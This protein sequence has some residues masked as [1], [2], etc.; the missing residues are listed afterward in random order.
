MS[1]KL[2]RPGG[3]LSGT[4]KARRDV[5]LFPSLAHSLR[6]HKLRSPYSGD[7]D[8]VFANRVGN[9]FLQGNV[10]SLLVYQGRDIVF[11]SRQLGHANPKITLEIYADLWNQAEQAEAMRQGME[12]DFA[13]MVGGNGP[14]TNDGRGG[15]RTG[16]AEAANLVPLGVLR[17]GGAPS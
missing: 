1:P 12:S 10:S 5:M 3:G 15:E 16:V 9:G 4:E 2:I 7:E 14:A 13:A 17:S 11:V 6:Q 8:F